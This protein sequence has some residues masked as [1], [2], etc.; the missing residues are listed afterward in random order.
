MTDTIRRYQAG[1]TDILNVKK[2]RRK[3]TIR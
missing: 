1:L 2:Q 3:I